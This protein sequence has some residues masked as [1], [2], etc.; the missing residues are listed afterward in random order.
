MCLLERLLWLYVHKDGGGRV[1][2]QI[3]LLGDSGRCPGR[4]V[5]KV[6]WEEM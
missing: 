6:Q 3:S 5:A 1:S 2:I 4:M